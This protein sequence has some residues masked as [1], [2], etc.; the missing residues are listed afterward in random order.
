VGI[1]HH[2]FGHDMM[3][4]HVELFKQVI[5]HDFSDHKHVIGQMVIGQN[6]QRLILK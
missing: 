6:N 4:C 3:P 5:Q 1:T 2:Y